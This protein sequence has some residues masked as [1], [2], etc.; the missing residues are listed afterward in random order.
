M[1]TQD[2][3]PFLFSDIEDVRVIIKA[4]G[5][6]YSVIGKNDDAL[7]VRIALLSVLL[8]DHYVVDT[9]LENLENE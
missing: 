5:K 1:T 9:V 6:H 8:E 4:N 7:E 2:E 3:T